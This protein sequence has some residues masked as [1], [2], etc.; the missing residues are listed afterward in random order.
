MA[1]PRGLACGI[2]TPSED[3]EPGTFDAIRALLDADSQLVIGP[4]LPRL[5]VIP[6]RDDGGEVAGGLWGYTMFQW[7]HI[8]MVF[9]PDAIRGR[10]IGSALMK[11][12]EAEAA[13]R[14]CLGSHVDAFAFQA[15]PFYQKLGYTLFG[16]LQNYPPGQ[17]RLFFYKKLVPVPPSTL[18]AA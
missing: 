1:S 14:G 6:I 13:C 9:V 8:Q 15:G 17:Q 11:A 16:A 18:G 3:P 7:L 2:L 10:R 12:A 4:A 5:L